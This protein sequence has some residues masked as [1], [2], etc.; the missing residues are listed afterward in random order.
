MLAITLYYIKCKKGKLKYHYQSEISSY[1]LLFEGSF[2]SLLG[3][4]K[5]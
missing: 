5:Q 1:F 3:V 4:I 2:K